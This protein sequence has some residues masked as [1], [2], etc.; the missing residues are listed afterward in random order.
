MLSVVRSYHHIWL[1]IEAERF[2]N[3]IHRI[4]ATLF[5]WVFQFRHFIVIIIVNETNARYWCLVTSYD[6]VIMHRIKIRIRIFEN[7]KLFTN[8]RVE[9]SFVIFAL[10]QSTSILSMVF[11]WC[12]GSQLMIT[13]NIISGLIFWSSYQKCRK[14]LLFLRQ[15]FVYIS[16]YAWIDPC[17]HLWFSVNALNRQDL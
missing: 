7:K 4:L 14:L 8:G 10:S 11:A 6:A 17:A 16:V 5:M 2:A 9:K 12:L 3:E 13:I 15:T 1:W